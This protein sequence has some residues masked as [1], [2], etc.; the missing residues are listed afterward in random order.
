MV[1]SILQILEHATAECPLILETPCG[2]GTEVCYK[3]E[4]FAALLIRVWQT[5]PIAEHRLRVCIDSCHVFAAGYYPLQYTKRLIALLGE[6]NCPCRP[7]L[8]HFNDSCHHKGSRRD[9]HHH[10]RRDGGEIGIKQMALLLEYAI[11][12]N[13]DCVVE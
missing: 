9:R 5:A 11:T 12:Q 8:L 2:E 1:T 13:I 6:A 10:W 3:V 4:D 7:V